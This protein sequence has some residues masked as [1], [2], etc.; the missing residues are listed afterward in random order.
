MGALSTELRVLLP[1]LA[2]GPGAAGWDEAAGRRRGEETGAVQGAVR[3]VVI[4]KLPGEFAAT[5]MASSLSGYRKQ[6]VRNDR[7]RPRAALALRG[8]TL[9]ALPV[10]RWPSSCPTVP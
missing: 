4:G 3:S 10:T 5:D 1:A 9:S 8:W 6:V 2:D 7:E